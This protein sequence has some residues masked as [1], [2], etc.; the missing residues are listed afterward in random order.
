MRADKFTL[1]LVLEV[2]SL[3]PVSVVL[4]GRILQVSFIRLRKFSFSDCSEFVS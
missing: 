3:L 4:A 2:F 1:F